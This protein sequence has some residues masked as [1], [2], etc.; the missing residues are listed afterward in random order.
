MKKDLI[1]KQL[2]GNDAGEDEPEEILNSYFV[3]K[4]E[5]EPFYNFDNKFHIVRSRK[6]VG[7]SAL[8]KK[9][10]SLTSKK[11]NI[12]GLYLKGSDLIALQNINSSSPY[13]L[14]YG[15]QQRI[16]SRITV[17][18][19][20][21]LNLALSDDSISLVEAA[22][23]S[24]FKGRNIVGSLL[25]RLKI[26]LSKV[27][28]DHKKLAIGN[29]QALLER[30]SNNRNLSVWLFIDDIDATFI[31]REDQRLLISTFFSACRNLIN[32]VN[33]LNI[34]AS[35]RTD[36]W[37][38]ISQH[39][40]ALDKCEQYVI[41]IHWTTAETGMILKRKI[42]SY[43]QRKYPTE[44]YYK[45]L[46]ILKNEKEIFKL[47]FSVPF[48]WGNRYRSPH[49][50]IH[51][52][53][54]GRPRWAAHLCKLAAKN[55]VSKGYAIITI[56]S[57]SNV[58]EKYGHSRL[59]DLYKEHAHQCPK[60]KSIIEAF[61]SGPKRYTTHELFYRITDKIIR[62]EGL[63]E[64]DGIERSGDS[65]YIAHFLYRIGFIQAR[66]DDDKTGLG[67]IKYEERPSLLTSRANLDD[68]HDWEIHPS[69][70]DI[71]R[72]KREN[73][74]GNGFKDSCL[75]TKQLV[76]VG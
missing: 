39:D 43:F 68:G 35:V 66:D 53:S 10:Q 71:L 28:I 8:L 40:E 57:I 16:C 19:G 5:F 74:R 4:I 46:N 38:I 76:K 75:P 55:A 29:A 65:L 23:L 24:G 62:L 44:N 22:E 61:S 50:P 69:Y 31:N 34:R 13:S 11:D 18:I 73:L 58:M 56:N 12:I 54:A 72:I 33:G 9:T 70:R 32:S 51:I 15:W 49:Q 42:L 20:K 47:I 48:R 63:P 30:F 27:E 17:E 60:I 2:F 41:D 45:N 14:V 3:D 25:E 36:V 37:S 59:M 6:G 1:S 7:K 67:F 52:L 21:R 64:I 26:K